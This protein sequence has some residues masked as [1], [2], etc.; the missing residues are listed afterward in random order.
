MCSRMADIIQ[1]RLITLDPVG[2]DWTPDCIA[3]KIDGGEMDIATGHTI[4][5]TISP[6]T[7]LINE[8]CSSPVSVS[9]IFE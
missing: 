7:L 9:N 5:F 6:W 8:L 4:S 2:V 1:F 3:I